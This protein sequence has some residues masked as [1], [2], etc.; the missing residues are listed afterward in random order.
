MKLK[1]SNTL[2]KASPDYLCGNERQAAPSVKELPGEMDFSRL[3]GAGTGIYDAW[4]T[5]LTQANENNSESFYME[6]PVFPQFIILYERFIH[7]NGFF[8]ELARVQGETHSFTQAMEICGELEAL[9]E[10]AAQISFKNAHSRPEIL[11]MTNNE[12]R[13][14]LMEI[15]RQCREKER[16]MTE[17]LRSV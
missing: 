3:R 10:E 11:A 6:F 15:L 13:G 14:L 16:E 17:R 7:L 9:A 1:E 5:L 2:K 4:I 12:R 8:R